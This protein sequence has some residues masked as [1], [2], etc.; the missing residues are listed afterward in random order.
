MSQ[1]GTYS[2]KILKRKPSKIE[3]TVPDQ[4]KQIKKWY[5]GK[6]RDIIDLSEDIEEEDLEEEEED[7]ARLITNEQFGILHRFDNKDCFSMVKKNT[8]EGIDP[9]YVVTKFGEYTAKNKE[10][11]DQRY[12]IGDRVRCQCTFIERVWFQDPYSSWYIEEEKIVNDYLK[13][14]AIKEFEKDDTGEYRDHYKN[15]LYIKDLSTLKP[16]KFNQHLEALNFAPTAYNVD[17]TLWFE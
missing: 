3:D 15:F 2:K 17:T 6:L 9:W 10:N 16:E 13:K 14:L 7:W 5:N 12:I 11:G 4:V 8:Q 1:L